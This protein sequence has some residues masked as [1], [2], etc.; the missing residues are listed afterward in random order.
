[1]TYGIKHDWTLTMKS[2]GRH[3]VSSHPQGD[4][5]SAML[6]SFPSCHRVIIVLSYYIFPSII[7]EERILLV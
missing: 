6:E 5:V 4:Y 2:H 3:G 1:M 7:E